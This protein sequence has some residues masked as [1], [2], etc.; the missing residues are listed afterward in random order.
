EK[1][2]RKALHE[3]VLPN[4]AYAAQTPTV[5][6]VAAPKLADAGGYEV[7][8]VP[9]EHAWD[10]RFANNGWMQEAPDP[11]TK[12]TWGNAALISAA[13]AKE[14]GV[15]GHGEGSDREADL[16]T[17]STASGQVTLPALIAVGQADKSITVAVG[18]GRKVVGRVGTGVGVATGALRT[19]AAPGYLTGVKVAK[20]AGSEKLAR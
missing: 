19:S 3:A 5:G 15:E 10:G 14:L 17:L 13:T 8:F 7:S 2:W 20:A 4:T 11:M 18:Q 16:L 1:D 12:L 6:D 9:D